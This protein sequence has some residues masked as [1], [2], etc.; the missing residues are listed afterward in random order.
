[1]LGVCLLL[2]AEAIGFQWSSGALT[3]EF[4]G[5]P[6]EAAHYV[7]GLMIRDYLAS[8]P[9]SEF[10]SPLRFAENYYLHYPKVAFGIWPPL[11]HLLLGVWM[12]VVSTSRFSALLLMAICTALLGA[13]V[14]QAVRR[15][16]GW[17][18][19]IAAGLL[20]VSLPSIQESGSMV[21]ADMLV[22]LLCF[23]AAQAYGRF[24]ESERWQDSARFGVDASL[25][26]LTKYNALA[27]AFVPIVALALTRRFR[28]LTRPQFWLGGL[29]VLALSGPW[30][31]PMRQMVLYAAEPIP[32]RGLIP[33]VMVENLQK[34]AGLT[35]IGLFLLVA[36][37]FVATIS[38]AFRG[39]RLEGQ[40]AALAALPACVWI[41]YSIF[42]PSIEVRYLLAAAPALLVFLV[43]GA[44]RLAAW[45]PFRGWSVR[46]KARALAAVLLLVYAGE[47]LALPEKRRHGFSEAA[48]FLLARPEL[49]QAAFLVS[50]EG[51]GE[52]MLIAEIAMR[53]QRPG[54]IILRASKMLAKSTWMS[55]DYKLLYR[56][57]DEIQ[58]FLESIPVSIVVL[59]T[60]PG[61]L[62]MEHHRQLQR[63]VEAYPEKWALLR[64]WPQ[65]PGGAAGPIRLYHLRAGGNRPPGPIRIDMSYTLKRFITSVDREVKPVGTG[66]EREGR[67]QYGEAAQP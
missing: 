14:C 16:F 28:L 64:A 56:G 27:L 51:E 12:L 66:G 62:A 10:R 20:L 47:T 67:R 41:F 65:G 30:Y 11:F 40:W 58:A 42:Y 33:A 48:E 39:R 9:D 36:A 8:L 6:D 38:G 18:A 60:A 63:T 55:Q 3:S 23:R 21:M 19:G 17:P 32:D 5:A 4:G 15:Q 22:A 54:H 7:T 35:G 34:L 37:G 61:W 57:P 52:G 45:L 53:E 24:L 1:L 59:D 43:A 2:L 46:G 50:S 31:F 44:A 29:I 13:S 49:R 25:G 26:L